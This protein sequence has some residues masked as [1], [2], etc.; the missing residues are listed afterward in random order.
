LAGTILIAPWA[1]LSNCLVQDSEVKRN[2][3]IENIMLIDNTLK[4]VEK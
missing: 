1:I 4:E 2:Q 3:N